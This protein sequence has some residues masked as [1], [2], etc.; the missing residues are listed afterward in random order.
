MWVSTIES[1]GPEFL[2][3]SPLS[4]EACDD[5]R[6]EERKILGACSWR[7]SPK[8][9]GFLYRVRSSFDQPFFIKQ[10]IKTAWRRILV[11]TGQ[12]QRCGTQDGDVGQCRANDFQ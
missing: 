6:S 1:D 5:N 2:L 8:I 4:Q 7:A 10:P 12:A 11:A 3:P 9:H